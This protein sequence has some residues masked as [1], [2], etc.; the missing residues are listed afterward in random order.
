MYVTNLMK[1]VYDHTN[2]CAES[3]TD[4]IATFSSGKTA[5]AYKTI[6][7]REAWSMCP[8]NMGVSYYTQRV[9]V[10]AR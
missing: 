6:L 8:N 7:N 4:L 9:R 3:R 1:S 2:S 5:Q 10:R